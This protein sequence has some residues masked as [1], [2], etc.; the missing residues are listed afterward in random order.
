[1]KR[2]AI[3]GEMSSPILLENAVNNRLKT[4]N[5]VPEKIIL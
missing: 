4:L 1:M 3:V 2:I 5:S